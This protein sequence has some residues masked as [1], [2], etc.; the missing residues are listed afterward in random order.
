MN[1]EDLRDHYELYAIGIAEDPE[2]S[3]LRDHLRRGCE[4]C[5]VGM[6]RARTMAAFL[7][8]SATPMEPSS[9]LRRRILASIGFEQRSFGWT[10]LFAALAMFGLVAVVY[11]AGR[12]K[13]LATNLANLRTEMRSQTIELTRMHD[14]VGILNSPDTVQTSFGTGA[15]QPPKGKVFVHP[16]RGVL[17]IASNLPPAPAGKIYEMCLLPKG[18]KPQPAGL[19]RSENDGTA[20]HVQPGAVDVQTLAAVAV[21][22]EVESGTTE[23]TL[24]PVFAAA[25]Q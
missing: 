13:D 24:P 19:F 10:P 12:E 2:R 6:K 4:V 18:G 9:K 22:L 7:G 23:P 3:E 15:P 14:A 11:F 5:M 20:M 21:T 1:C 25:M 16:G 17:L 8:G